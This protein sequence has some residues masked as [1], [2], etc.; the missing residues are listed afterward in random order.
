MS[1]DKMPMFPRCDYCGRSEPLSVKDKT[2]PGCGAEIARVDARIDEL[3]GFLSDLCDKLRT[4]G[5]IG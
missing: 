2:C 5:V 1:E 3:R 4:N